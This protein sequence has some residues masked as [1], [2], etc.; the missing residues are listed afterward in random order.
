MKNQ[1]RKRND[2][3]FYDRMADR[4][5]QPD[6][7]IYTLSYLN[8]PRFAFFDR[9]VKEW[10]GLKVL[11]VGC[12]GGY[13]CEFMA[14]KGAI[15]SGID[16]SDPCI[17]SARNHAATQGWVIDYRVGQAE[18]LPWQND[19]FDAVICVD[20]LEHVVDWQKTVAEIYRVL[21]PQ[22]Y[23]FFDTINRNLK[24]K[25]I[26][27][28]LLEDILQEIPSG[29]HDWHK[30]IQPQELQYCL[31]QVGFSDIYIKGFDLFGVSFYQN[32]RAYIHYKNTGGFKAKISEDT[33]LM[34]IG[35]AM[36]SKE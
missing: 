19:T 6:E 32:I 28:H 14:A 34:Y 30:F 16:R 36:K 8:L 3:E 9:Y 15:V 5:W 10:Q 26:F 13:S 35:K 24:S 4:W 1:P 31:G 21:Q 23:F 25:F 18:T 29:V 22:G 11:D 2:L 7:K 27:I 20:V 17:I 12:G 33:S